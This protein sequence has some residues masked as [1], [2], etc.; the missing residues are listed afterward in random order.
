MVPPDIS[1]DL[2]RSV[3]DHQF[4]EQKRAALREEKG[5]RTAFDAL[6]DQLE[7]LKTSADSDLGASVEELLNGSDGL[8]GTR[9]GVR[10][11]VNRRLFAALG[12]ALFECQRF[13]S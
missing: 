11:Y 9:L 6:K 12:E 2:Q 4:L 3:E 5:A 1:L 13:K 10:S 7:E 8:Q